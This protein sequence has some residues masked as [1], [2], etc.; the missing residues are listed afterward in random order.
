[1][2][3]SDFANVYASI[4]NLQNQYD[5]ITGNIF[6]NY[7]LLSQIMA[8]QTSVYNSIY[9]GTGNI[10]TGN[11]AVNRSANISENT[12][13]SGNVLSIGFSTFTSQTPLQVVS[14]TVTIG[15]VSA[16]AAKLTTISFGRT[17]RNVPKITI[18]SS[19]GVNSA[20]LSHLAVNKT[21]TQFDLYSYNAFT[22]ATGADTA[23]D[24]IAIG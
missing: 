3:V 14:N 22:S 10:V 5:Q 15:S 19:A 9:Y 2:S 18:T 6:S 12:N 20:S 21:T 11:L 8:Q 13:V 17:F 16:T 1:M 4:N 24:Y 23:V 7:N